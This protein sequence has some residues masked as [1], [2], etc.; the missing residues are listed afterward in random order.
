MTA[1]PV[2]E[3]FPTRRWRGHA[4][5]VWIGGRVYAVFFGPSLHGVIADAQQYAAG[6]RW[7]VD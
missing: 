5:L 1:R 4:A 2:I 3:T 6:M 7:G